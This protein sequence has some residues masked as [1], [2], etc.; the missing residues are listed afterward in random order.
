VSARMPIKKIRN[1][2]GPRMQ[3]LRGMRQWGHTT[4]LE[5]I[6]DEDTIIGAASG[7]Q[8][9]RRGF[10]GDEA[11]PLSSEKT[12]RLRSAL[13]SRGGLHMCHALGQD[14]ERG[15]IDDVREIVFL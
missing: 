11:R 14:S 4:R 6:S 1:G 2:R 9:Q 10:R 15:E 8:D 5:F 7:Q 12:S 13:M 3:T